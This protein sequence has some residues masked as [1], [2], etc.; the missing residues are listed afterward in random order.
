MSAHADRDETV[1]AG[2]R[3]PVGQRTGSRTKSNSRSS[4]SSDRRRGAMRWRSR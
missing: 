2:V 3:D 4:T 1:R